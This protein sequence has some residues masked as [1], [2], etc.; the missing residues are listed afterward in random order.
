MC[1]KTVKCGAR[2]ISIITVD[3]VV[4]RIRMAQQR[5]DCERLVIAPD[6][7][8]GMLT[9]DLAVAKLDVMCRAATLA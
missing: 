2:T 9:R 4:E 3:E 8:L 1:R 7:G 5:I 6:C